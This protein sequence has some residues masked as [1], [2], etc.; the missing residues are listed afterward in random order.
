MRL[1]SE[2]L[3]IYEQN[4]HAL[5]TLLR[6]YEQN[7]HAKQYGGDN[8]PTEENADKHKASYTTRTEQTGRSKYHDNK[9]T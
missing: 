4:K 7:K 5:K 3:R 6:T 1:S 2:V 9:H 8:I